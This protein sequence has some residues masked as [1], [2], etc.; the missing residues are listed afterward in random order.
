MAAQRLSTG[1]QQYFKPKR[2]L[3]DDSP[4]SRV[5]AGRSFGQTDRKPGSAVPMTYLLND[6][7]DV[8]PFRADF[9][10]RYINYPWFLMMTL[11]N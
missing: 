2:Y 4:Y 7:G 3:W 10:C 6:H 8:I 1:N 9:A 11:N 5:G